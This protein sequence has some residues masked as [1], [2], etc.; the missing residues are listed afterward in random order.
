MTGSYRKLG[1]ALAALCLTTPALWAQDLKESFNQVIAA[2]DQGRDADAA[3]QLQKILSSSPSQSDVYELWQTTPHEE[4]MQILRG[5]TDVHLAGRRLVSLVEQA[6]QERKNDK[7]AINALLGRL[8]SSDGDASAFSTAVRE[9]A[10]NHGEYA[11]PQLV[12]WLRD[13]GDSEKQALAA[14][15]LMRIGPPVVLPLI[16]C[17]SA[18]DSFLRR[19]SARLLGSIGD[20]RAAGALAGMVA[21]ETEA[22]CQA[23]ARSALETMG[24]KGSACEELCRQ[25]DLYH[26]RSSDV[27]AADMWSEVVWGLNEDRLVGT[28]TART[29]YADAMARKCFEHAMKIDPACAAAL[30]G[31]ARAHAGVIA[32][33]E[34]AAM[35]GA[36]VTEMQATVDSAHLHLGLVGPA[37]ANDGLRASVA[38][39]DSSTGVVLARA[40]AEMSAGAAQATALKDALNARDGALRSEAA[41]ALGNMAT[42]G[43][44]SADAATVDA[45]GAVAAREVLRL[46]FVI[47]PNE[48]RSAALAKS[49]GGIQMSVNT[50]QAGMLGL[51]M[52]RRMPGLDAIVLAD[53][54]GDVT[55]HQLVEEIRA[56]P[57][58]AAVPIF[59]VSD[60]PEA[61]QDA[62]AGLE[63]TLLASV[64]DVSSVDA[65]LAGKL[66]SERQRA[67]DL[68]SKAASLLAQLAGTRTPISAG[69]VT[70]LVTALGR[71]DSVAVSAAYALAC[72][73]SSAEHITALA[74][75]VADSGRSEP[76][77]EAAARAVSSIVGRG[78]AAG[79]AVAMLQGVVSSD[80][81]LSVRRAAA[82]ALGNALGNK[83]RAAL[84]SAT[85]PTQ[86]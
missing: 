17:L 36:D 22:V 16:E 34:A 56:E 78:V 76:V 64:E 37:A 29:L 52:L 7:E 49:L 11:A 81:P 62:F 5:P 79:D 60:Q 32:S 85:A 15:A 14:H 53:S 63:L 3:R 41:I 4:W 47:D 24:F 31:L 73:G 30:P 70:S 66:G 13:S 84:L 42:W 1:L 2:L 8:R 21:V 45:L 18:S 20:R 74:A 38:S 43:K 61:A 26:M 12:E 48:T 28:P 10:N 65:A 58:F 77:R 35:T 68:A 75:V 44:G 19:E 33:V 9:L 59:L 27:L 55:V 23:A 72:C 57:N 6:R 80:A 82:Q 50:A 39:G 40:L 86:G 51:S 67:E 46:G 69:A 25:G 83:E 71:A 54:I